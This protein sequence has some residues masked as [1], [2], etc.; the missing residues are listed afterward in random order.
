MNI[1]ENKVAVSTSIKDLR[2]YLDHLQA[3]TRMMCLTPEGALSGQCNFLSANLSARSLF[4]EDALANVSL[5]QADDG[6]ISGELSSSFPK[7]ALLFSP[8]G[9]SP[10]P[11]LEPHSAPN[12]VL[13]PRCL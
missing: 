13:H 8:F 1:V 9:P 2:G 7:L 10:F 6:S 5:E 12:L 11:L 3:S 4:G